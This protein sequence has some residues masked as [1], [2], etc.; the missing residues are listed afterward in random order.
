M[1]KLSQTAYETIKQRIL[2]SN[3][4]PGARI[5]E[6]MIANELS[7]SR[8]PVREA[9]QR[10]AADQMITIYPNRYAEVATFD[11]DRVR[12][13]GAI[14]LALD[15]LSV[16]SCSYNGSAAEFDILEEVE[17]E[18]EA[19]SR[20]GDKKERIRLECAFHLKIARIAKN[21]DLIRQQEN[22]YQLISMILSRQE[23][24]SEDAEAQVEQHKALIRAIRV[25]D[26]STARHLLCDHLQKTHG[27]SNNF[28]QYFD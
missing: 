8:T 10:L 26:I 4:E 14:R 1:S 7:I 27:L 5:T 12:H 15:M 6:D 16:Y 20:S 2:D 28:V 3:Y 25:Q 22:L 23:L 24:G 17:R 18:Y 19:A 9:F 13:I 21:D 11:R